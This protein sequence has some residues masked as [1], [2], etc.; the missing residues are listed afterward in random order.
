MK[1]LMML[2]VLGAAVCATTMM[3]ESAQAQVDGYRF[4]VGIRQ[5]R[6][7]RNFGVVRNFGFAHGAVHHRI[8]EPP[9]FA[10]YPPVYYS[11]Q[12]IR[13]PYG[14]SP[15]AAPA[16]IVPVEMQVVPQ[17]A[18]I[19]NPHALPDSLLDKPEDDDKEKEGEKTT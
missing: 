7:F 12:I 8:A 4:G 5:S 3:T 14:V 19:V 17:P 11:D 6:Q 13:R 10:L 15:F 2:A 16:G 18:R 1:R 9:Y